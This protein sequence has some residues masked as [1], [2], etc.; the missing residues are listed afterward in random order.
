MGA[1][2]HLCTDDDDGGDDGGDG[3]G[4]GDDGGDGDGD[5]P[6]VAWMPSTAVD[7]HGQYWT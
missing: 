4:D 2:G 7:G 5:S 1:T 3:G 6:T